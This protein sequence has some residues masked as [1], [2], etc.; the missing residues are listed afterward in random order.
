MKN[1]VK[2]MY[3]Q[4]WMTFQ[5]CLVADLTFKHIITSV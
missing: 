4:C 2:Q 3:R 1:E 5:I